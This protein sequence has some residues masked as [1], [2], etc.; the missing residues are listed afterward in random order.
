MAEESAQHTQT[1]G[2]GGYEVVALDDV[3]TLLVESYEEVASQYDQRGAERDEV[4]SHD[5]QQVAAGLQSLADAQEATAAQE[6]SENDASATVVVLDQQQ[7]A[8]VQRCWGWAKAG[9]ATGLFI[10]LVTTLLVAALFGSRLWSAFSKGWR[11]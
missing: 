11:K 5:L 2:G 10:C 8:D 6:D 3:R 4:L 1:D 9:L 7:W